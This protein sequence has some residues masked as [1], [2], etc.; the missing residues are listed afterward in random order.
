MKH[1]SKHFTFIFLIVF[2]LLISCNDESEFHPV[3]GFNPYADQIIEMEGKAIEVLVKSNLT[4]NITVEDQ[5]ARTWCHVDKNSGSGEETVLITVDA[6]PQNGD[7][8]SA[9]VIFS[10]D[11]M[12]PRALS[13]EQKAWIN[14]DLDIFTEIED[15]IFKQYCIDSNFDAD[16]DGILST[17]EA[18]LVKTIDV[19][20]K[21]ILSLKGIEYFP[22][23]TTLLCSKTQI[24]E[25]DVTK[26]AMLEKLEFNDTPIA[27]TVNVTKCSKLKRL[28]CYNT[29]ITEMDL[30]QCVVL[31]D[32]RCQNTEM[33]VVDVTYCFDLMELFCQNTG[34][35]ALNISK[36]EYLTRLEA[37]PNPS[38]TVIYVWDEF[39]IGSPPSNFKIPPIDVTY[40][41][42][43]R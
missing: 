20:G 37:N 36:N 9:E 28:Y 6:N 7:L 5:D 2:S 13:I 27:G 26:C 41:L 39:P 30:S 3:L 18:A 43:P 34:I 35:T 42:I 25:L 15:D 22:E 12:E 1:F 10:A 38:L 4:W 33:K 19:S 40:Q 24:T 11:G 8:R 23:L 21:A 17:A 16:G 29:K 31:Q 32:F 14:P